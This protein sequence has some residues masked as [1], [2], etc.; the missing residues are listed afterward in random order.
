MYI[1]FSTV[2]VS[3]YQCIAVPCIAV[4]CIADSSASRGMSP[5]F[6][7]VAVVEHTKETPRSGLVARCRHGSGTARTA[8]GL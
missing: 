6:S 7:D 5:V 1:F 3:V 8:A 4:L 2:D